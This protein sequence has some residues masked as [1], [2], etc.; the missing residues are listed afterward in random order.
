MH[1]G[2]AILS[3]D[4]VGPTIFGIIGGSVEVVGN[5]DVVEEGTALLGTPHKAQ[6]LFDA[7]VD[8]GAFLFPHTS[9]SHSS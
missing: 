2:Q 8:P 3:G 7:K 9:H 6:T 5:I 4:N 1:V